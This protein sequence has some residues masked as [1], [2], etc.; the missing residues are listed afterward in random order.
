MTSRNRN[1][2]ENRSRNRRNNRNNNSTNNNKKKKS[3]NSGKNNS[4]MLVEFGGFEPIMDRD[5]MIDVTDNHD[6]TGVCQSNSLFVVHEADVG[7]SQLV[8]NNAI[9]YIR[10]SN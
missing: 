3:N 4:G 5:D 6:N 1:R 10:Y 9:K 8:V 2:N 7:C